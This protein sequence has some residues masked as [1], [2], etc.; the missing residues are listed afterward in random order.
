MVTH[1]FM[2]YCWPWIRSRWNT[3]GHCFLCPSKYKLARC[4]CLNNK[5][6]RNGKKCFYQVTKVCKIYYVSQFTTRNV[7]IIVRKEEWFNRRMQLSEMSHLTYSMKTKSL[8][9]KF[10]LNTHFIHI[11]QRIILFPNNAVINNT[12]STW[13]PFCLITS[14]SLIFRVIDHISAHVWSIFFEFFGVWLISDLPE[15]MALVYTLC[16]YKNTPRKKSI[17]ITSGSVLT[18]HSPFNTKSVYER[19]FSVT[20]QEPV[21]TSAG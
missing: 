3:E 10:R 21:L 16:F 19:M 15:C 13:P 2:H 18:K 14:L 8:F 4:I 5:K 17:W 6:A 7:L 12:W 1:S 9:K 11:H 20:I